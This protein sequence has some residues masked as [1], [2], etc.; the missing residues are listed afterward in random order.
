MKRLIAILLVV[1]IFTTLLA[2]CGN[3]QDGPVTTPSKGGE[4]SPTA[5]TEELPSFKAGLV[6]WGTSD[7]HGRYLSEAFSWLENL[8]GE[9]LLDTGALTPE[10]MITSAENLIQAGCD[11]IVFCTY[12]GESIVPTISN[13]CKDNGVYWAMWDTTVSSEIQTMINENPYFCGTTNEDQVD[14]GYRATKYMID[15]GASD[16][17]LLKYGIGIPTCDLRE[18]G[19]ISAIQEAGANVTYTLMAPE[20]TKKAVQD[21]LVSNPEANAF[22]SLGAAQSYCTPAIQ[23]IASVGRKGEVQVGGFDFGDD[24]AKQVEDGDL[25]IVIGGHVTTAFFSAI[26][27]LNEFWGY[28][29]NPDNAELVIPYVDITSPEDFDNFNKYIV[30]EEPPYTNEELQQFIIKNNPDLTWESFQEKVIS[31]GIED[32]IERHGN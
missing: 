19:A 15:A 30:G 10:A 18:E 24:M 32:V 8:G 20:D 27:C 4:T 31:F 17:I 9:V 21:V 16:F 26:M 6:L 7:S 29:L 5:G 13:L 25:S 14:A 3:T 1:A 12:V 2:S 22:L 23:A 11:I 28:S